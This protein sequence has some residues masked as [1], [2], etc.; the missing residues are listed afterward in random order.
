V[1]AL[2]VDHVTKRFV[3]G[4][5]KKDV[6]AVNDVSLRIE[7]GEVYGVLGANGGG[8]STLIRLVSTLLTLDAGRVE[9]FGHDIEREEMAVKR[10]INRVSVDAAFFKKLSP[11]ENLMYAARLYGLD[12]GR[13]RSE[14]IQ[15]LG[16]LGVAESRLGRPLEQM[17]RGM[18]QKVA[19]ARAILTSPTLLLLDEPTT[20]LDPRSKLDVQTFIEELRDDHDAS[21]VLTTHDLAEAERLCDRIT[22][23][24]QGR[25]VVEGTPQELKDLVLRDH[26]QPPTLES[27]FMTYTGR[28][29]DDD[30]EED[31]DDDE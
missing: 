29:L 26:G 2:L 28:S 23:L 17:S 1:P 14:A 24:D 4:R 30:V 5:K 18:Q 6:F 8:K 31:G 9:V 3:V 21:I 27:V 16:R 20:G 19:I 25:M 13:A 7:R 22:I 15:I 10:L 11:Y 12:T